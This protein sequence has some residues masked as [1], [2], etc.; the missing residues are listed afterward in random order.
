MND[1][2]RPPESYKPGS[3]PVT[4]YQLAAD[5]WDKRIGSA[6]V[7]A[8][9]W[10][11]ATLSVSV[12]ALLLGAGLI[13]QSQKSTVSPYVVQVNGDG[14]VQAVGPARQTN[15][16]PERPVIEYF[17]VQ[18]VTKV[19]TVPLDPVVA[20][21]QWLSAYDY[22]RQ[23]AA[24]TLNEIALREEPFSRIGFETVAVRMKSVVPL[25]RDTY[26]LRWEE[27]TYSKEGVT[28]GTKGMTGIFNIEIVPPTD[29]RKLQANPLGLF[30]R[31]FS[32]SRDV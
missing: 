13:Y 14:V 19:R 32:W 29:E 9:N 22:L 31:Q 21:S 2:N 7:Q 10:R 28:L 24:N 11:L 25:S 15:Y 12:L 3:A 8:K 5:E 1:F 4:P 23:G 26:Q 6:T 27:A 30:I 18:F 17:I 20:K 16:K